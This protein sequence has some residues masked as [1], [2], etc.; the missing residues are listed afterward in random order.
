MS[1]HR[2][3]ERTLTGGQ[4]DIARRGDGGRETGGW[5]RITATNTETGF[6]RS[7]QSVTG[8]SYA[9]GGLPP[10][11][12]KVDVTAGR[13]ER[14]IVTLQVGQTAT[15]DLGVTTVPREIESVVVTATPL[16]ETRRPKSQ[17]TSR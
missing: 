7:T 12:Y 14:E 5:R 13:R 10:G 16:F 8:G 15:L 6:S 3:A 2:S 11:T 4:R 17:A 9:L 1:A